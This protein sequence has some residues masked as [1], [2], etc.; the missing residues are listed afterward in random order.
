MEEGLIASMPWWLPLSYF[1]LVFAIGTYVI[2]RLTRERVC[3]CGH[4][5]QL[6]EHYRAGS[7]C[8]TCGVKDGEKVCP[9]F[10]QR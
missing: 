4:S 9:K 1:V 5:P 7:D 8:G 3:V 6:H 10:R 2:A